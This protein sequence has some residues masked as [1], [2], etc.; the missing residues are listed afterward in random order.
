MSQVFR[1]ELYG[2]VSP[3][4]YEREIKRLYGGNLELYKENVREL[5][6]MGNFHNF[7]LVLELCCGTGLA[8]Q[9]IV[10]RHHLTLRACDA[11]ISYLNYA[12]E[13]VKREYFDFYE[14]C[15]PLE[16]FHADITKW[17]IKSLKE[18]NSIVIMCNAMTEMLDDIPLFDI[19]HAQLFDKGLF[20]YNIKVVDGK[21]AYP[22]QLFE[23]ITEKYP[24]EFPEGST[25]VDFVTPTKTKEEIYTLLSQKKFSLH[26]CKEKEYNFLN[27]RT[28]R[29]NISQNY[30]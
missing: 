13:H 18:E 6:D 4:D 12:R 9:E 5:L 26:T 21:R 14:P 11:N 8:T 20:L 24:K 7:S 1:R 2:R 22:V 30:L 27:S 29:H 19:A 23:A 3:E 17:D 15:I 25:I 16:F 10:K 28:F